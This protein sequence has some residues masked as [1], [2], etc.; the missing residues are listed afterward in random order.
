VLAINMT[1]GNLTAWAGE[2]LAANGVI[3]GL[4]RSLGQ[5]RTP[6]VVI[7]GASDRL[8]KPAC[9]RS[10]AALVPH[11]RLEMVPG[12]HMAPYTHHATIAAA[13]EALG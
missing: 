5:I 4:D 10:L 1:H 2:T 11:A 6:A 7:Q 12:G 9:G 8:V 13:V 3:A